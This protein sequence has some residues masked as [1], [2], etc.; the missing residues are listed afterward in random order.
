MSV[1]QVPSYGRQYH[2][3]LHPI[4]IASANRY[5][6]KII[7]SWLQSFFLS[8]PVKYLSTTAQIPSFSFNSLSQRNKL[9]GRCYGLLPEWEVRSIPFEECVVDLIRPWVVQVCGNPYE[10][11]TLA[12]IDTV[13]NLVELVRIDDKTSDNVARKFA[14]CWL[15]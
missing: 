5:Q 10:F 6:S 14:Q 15:A 3:C 12:A 7:L 4:L 1:H 2:I 9:E 13:T 8:N 11:S